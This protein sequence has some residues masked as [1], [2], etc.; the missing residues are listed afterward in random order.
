MDFIDDIEKGFQKLLELVRRKSRNETVA[1][2]TVWSIQDI[3]VLVSKEIT[4][5]TK[6][7]IKKEIS[8]H[9]DLMKLVTGLTKDH[10]IQKTTIELIIAQAM[11]EN[12]NGSTHS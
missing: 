6:P 8:G 4:Q 1:N 11:K 3:R 12:G 10:K 9:L 2:N 7:E 5:S